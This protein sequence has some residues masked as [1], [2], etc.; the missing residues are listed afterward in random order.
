M[1][2]QHAHKLYGPPTSLGYLLPQNESLG[3]NF[4]TSIMDES[5][6]VKLFAF[7]RQTLEKR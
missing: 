5:V 3:Y 1:S 6:R 2:K 4:Y 7:E